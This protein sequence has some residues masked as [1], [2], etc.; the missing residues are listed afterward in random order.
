MNLSTRQI[1]TVDRM[2]AFVEGTELADIGHVDPDGAYTVIC[3]TLER[4]LYPRLGKAD[5]TSWID[6]P[7]LEGMGYARGRATSL[8]RRAII[9]EG[10]P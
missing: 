5:K 3:R 9:E 4:V 8:E 7:C 10:R 2:R 6:L 1:R